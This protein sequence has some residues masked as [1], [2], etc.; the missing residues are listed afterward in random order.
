M[1]MTDASS[2]GVLLQIFGPMIR[3]SDRLERGTVDLTRPRTEIAR[4]QQQIAASLEGAEL[5]TMISEIGV[6]LRALT[7]DDIAA[8]LSDLPPR[9]QRRNCVAI[10]AYFDLVER[11]APHALG[12]IY[13]GSRL[14]GLDFSA[15]ILEALGKLRMAARG[16]GEARIEALRIAAGFI[17]ESLYK[18][19]M[20]VIYEIECLRVSREIRSELAFGNLVENVAHSTRNLLPGFVDRHAARMRNAAYHDRW[21]ERVVGSSIVDLHD[22]ECALRSLTPPQIYQ[23]LRDYY[24]DVQDF[25]HCLV[26]R[27]SASLMSLCSRPPFTFALAA[28][29]AG[30]PLDPA[31]SAEVRT[32][33]GDAIGGATHRLQDINWTPR[34]AVG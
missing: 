9:P 29:F 30:K 13:S 10:N 7:P 8:A 1:V 11:D 23:R 25:A 28:G 14:F 32:I 19:L 26:W 16:S 18:E 3:F 31:L 27:M 22:D 15:K 24:R 21:K 12:I 33:L 6:L 17:L 5:A 2:S 34:R 20:I 4:L